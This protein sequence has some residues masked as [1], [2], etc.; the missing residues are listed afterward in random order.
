MTLESDARLVKEDYSFIADHFGTDLQIGSWSILLSSLLFLVV[1]GYYVYVGYVDYDDDFT[2]VNLLILFLSSVLF[3]I[4]SMLFVYAS[5]PKELMK[6]AESIQTN[7]ASAM[8][9]TEKYFTHNYF[10]ISMWI[11][12]IAILP[13]FVYV[14]WAYQLA[15][16]DIAVFAFF[17]IAILVVYGALSLWL[18]STLPASLALNNG[19]GSTYFLDFFCCI[20]YMFDNKQFVRTHL[21]PDFLAG[22]WIFA[23]LIAAGVVFSIY[24]LYEYYQSPDLW[25][26]V[27]FFI[28]SIILSVG[29]LLF[30]YGSYPINLVQGSNIFWQLLC[31]QDAI[32]PSEEDLIE[33]DERRT[34]LPD[35]KP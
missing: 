17:L 34:L 26:Y 4:A 35:D 9:C 11:L 1:S 25:V 15:V 20:D 24:L 18:V 22:S 32:E 30:V 12:V 14:I 5:Y 7:D 13:V 8:S 28:S 23:I 21:S 6:L 3:V 29:A 33:R 31:C 19:T 27:V 16:I 2:Q 10:L